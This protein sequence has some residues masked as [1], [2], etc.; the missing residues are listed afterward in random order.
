MTISRTRNRNRQILEISIVILLIILAV[1]ILWR[2][3]A[4]KPLP[5]YRTVTYRVE[6]SGPVLI[7]YTQ[8]DDRTVSLT[9][10]FPPWRSTDMIFERGVDVIITVG[11]VSQV[12]SIKCIIL[13]DGKNWRESSANS[14]EDKVSCSGKVP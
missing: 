9:N 4:F 10:I 13:I 2:L 12:G 1:V 5:K 6:G 11:N 14:P 3:D 7:N 8:P